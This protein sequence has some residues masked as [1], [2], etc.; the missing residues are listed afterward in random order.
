MKGKL[1]LGPL[2]LL[3]TPTLLT[4]AEPAPS[5]QKVTFPS[6]GDT[7]T[8]YLALPTGSGRHPAIVVIQEWWGVNDWV[9]EQAQQFANEGYVALAVD[10]YRGRIA[11]DAEMAHELMRGLPQDRGVRDLTSA[12][13]WLKKRPDVD[14][15]RIGAI[16]WCMG[17]GYAAQLAIAAPSLKAVSINYGS[18]PTDKSALEH[19]HA[20]VL[21][22]FGGQDRGITP[23]DVHAFQSAME[24][25]GKHPDLKIYPDAGHAF[26][27]PNN[28]GGYRAAD[29]EDAQTR[30]HR[31]L[32]EH[33]HPRQ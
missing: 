21:G 17:G 13:A 33:L 5:L 3:C 19:I 8:A 23:D 16:G 15:A 32:A 22:N 25:L 4:I 9:R 11:T 1:L 18:L 12:V 2:F 27:N 6:G 24:S 30:S 10:L 14:P 29:A 31:F 7:A 20:A 26:E 28:T